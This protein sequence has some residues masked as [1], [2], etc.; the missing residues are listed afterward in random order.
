MSGDYATTE[1]VQAEYPELLTEA[2][3]ERAGRLITVAS[4]LLGQAVPI[5][6]EDQQQVRLAMIAVSDMVVAALSGEKYRGHSAYSWRNGALAG[7][8][9]LVASSGGVK[10]LDWHLAIF[11]SATAPGP[12]WDFPEPGRWW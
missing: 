6:L 1:Q 7:S 3:L 10:L 9:S 4:V 11:G 8:G 5:D 2:E 12:R